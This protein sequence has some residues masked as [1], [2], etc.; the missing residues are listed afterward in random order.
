MGPPYEHLAEVDEDGCLEDGV[1]S[2]VLKL[3]SELLQQQ[4]EEWRDWQRQPAGDVGDEQDE[5]PGSEI[6]KGRRA[7]VNPS[8]EPRRTPPQ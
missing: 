2:E 6:A 8:G 7:G 1:G 4:Q 3:E 5:L